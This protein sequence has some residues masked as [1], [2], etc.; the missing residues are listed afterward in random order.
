M[1]KGSAP[2]SYQSMSTEDLRT[3]RRWL[4]GNVVI[5]SL[6]AGMLFIMAGASAISPSGLDPSKPIMSSLAK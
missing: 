5:S 2:K 1:R 3:F 6:F 4:I